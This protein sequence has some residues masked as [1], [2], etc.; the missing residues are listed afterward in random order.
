MPTFGAPGERIGYT[1]YSHPQG[2]PPLLLLHGFT[3]SAASF[4][5]NIPVLRR[6]FTVI[7][8][9][10]L[11]HGASDAPIEVAPYRPEAAVSRLIGLLD[12]LGYHRALVCGHS[13][14]GALALRLAL[15]HPDRVAGLI[16]I[17][18]N[19]GAG[20]AEWRRQALPGLQAMA[21]QVRAEG[22]GILRNTRLYPAASRRLPEAARRL[23]TEDFD[24]LTAAGVA[25][26]A[27]GLTANVN[28]F[29]RLP[30]LTVPTL[31]VVGD[32]DR[33]FARRAP[34]FVANMPR[35]AV[36]VL[37]LEDAGHAA[38]LER[39]E[40]FDAAVLDFAQQ[41]GYLD[42]AEAED[43]GPEP[44]SRGWLVIAGAAFVA[45]GAALL[46]ASFILGDD[47]EP[48]RAEPLPTR[49]PTTRVAGERTA[50]AAASALT[51]SP[52][53]APTDTPTAEPT[54]T[55]T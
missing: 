46:A 15:D 17:N 19:S 40:E 49:P 13:L 20:D 37:T 54:A 45:L 14:G 3:A 39:P 33:D 32:R 4:I 16:V 44:G 55:D 35:A 9:D 8:V 31:V 25:G 2:A 5:S 24:R 6:D 47:N 42:T 22:T 53:A 51:P 23:L 41:L 52:S 50:G 38:N 36:Q 30:E 21:A 18:S 26:T 29:E 48:T 43:D 28:A 7:T 11:G 27:E 1:V 10:L 12:H 34:A